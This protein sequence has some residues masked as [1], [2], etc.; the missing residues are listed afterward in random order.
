MVHPCHPS[1][2]EAKA[3]RLLQVGGQPELHNETLSQTNK[4]SNNK[5]NKTTLLPNAELSMGVGVGVW[6]TQKRAL[7]P[8]R[9]SL[10]CGTGGLLCL[11]SLSCLGF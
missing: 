3:G 6:S 2:Q 5:R 11:N 10:L 7:P 8:N 4:T 1:T 9:F